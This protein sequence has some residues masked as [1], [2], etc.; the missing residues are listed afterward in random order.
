MSTAA[1]GLVYSQL[2]I[3]FPFGSTSNL[4]GHYFSIEKALLGRPSMLN[5]ERSGS[6]YTWAIR[7]IFGDEKLQKTKLPTNVIGFARLE[8]F[9]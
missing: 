6:T 1:A 2:V 3:F 4:S 7:S 5:L 8:T 9:V